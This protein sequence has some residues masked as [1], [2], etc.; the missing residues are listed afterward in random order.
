M[1]FICPISSLKTI[2]VSQPLRPCNSKKDK[3]ISVNL[4]SISKKKKKKML[5]H[6]HLADV[7]IQTGFPLHSRNM[8]LVHASQ[9]IDLGIVGVLLNCELQEHQLNNLFVSLLK[10][11]LSN[12]VIY[13]KFILGNLYYYFLLKHF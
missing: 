13:T 1:F 12:L 8:F 5:I 2:E 4:L 6:L 11:G 9:D 3:L 10:N 7:S